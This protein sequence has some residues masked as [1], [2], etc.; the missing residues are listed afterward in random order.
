L[1]YQLHRSAAKE[2]ADAAEFYRREGGAALALRFIAEFE[3]VMGLL[4]QH[5]GI[6]T[7]SAGE[8]R[9]FPLSVFP[10]SVI[11]KVSGQALRVLV[12]RHQSRSPLYGEGRH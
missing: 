3:R 8:R 12:V 6:G 10:Y 2:L 9:V 1:S 11:Y 4:Q 7:P 5:P